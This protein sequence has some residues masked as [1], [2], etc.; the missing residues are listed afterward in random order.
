MK[1]RLLFIIGGLSI[2]ISWILFFSQKKQH[3]QEIFSLE[4]LE[5]EFSIKRIHKSGAIFDSKKLDWMNSQYLMNMDLNTVSKRAQPYYA[6]HGLNISDEKKY[7][8]V[9]DNA[10]RRVNTLSKM[11]EA[12]QMF[13]SSLNISTDSLDLVNCDTSQALLKVI[14]TSLSREIGC[15]GDQFKAIVIEAGDGLGLRGKKLFFPV[16]I[17]LY[18]DPAGPDIPLIFSILGRDEALSRLSQVIKY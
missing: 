7:L 12:S 14:H 1:F 4:E 5:K 9:V 16:R 10:R 18:G 11:P 6:D 3:E 17:A 8:L 2:I 15:D 13:Y